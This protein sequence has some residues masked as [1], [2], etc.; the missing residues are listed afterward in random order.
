MKHLILL[1]LLISSSVYSKLTVETFNVGLAKG[2]VD[3]SVEREPEVLKAIKSSQ[4]DILCLQEA[5]DISLRKK[6]QK[7]LSDTYSDIYLTNVYQTTTSSRPSCGVKQL[8][9]KGKFVTCMQKQCADVEGDDF[10][11]C[12]LTKCDGALQ[13]LREEN[14]ECGS[15]LMAKVGKNQIVSIL[16]LI[17]PFYRAGLYAYRGSNGLVLLS[18][19]PLKNKKLIDFSD[20]STLNRR[21]A[22]QATVEY[23]GEDVQ[24]T[25]THL[26]AD[27]NVPYTGVS[28][29]WADENYNQIIRLLDE[30]LVEDQKSIVLGDFNCGHEDTEAGLDAELAQSC[31]LLDQYFA[32]PVRE[33]KECTYCEENSINQADNSKTN[34]LIDH[35]Y[36][37]GLKASSV[38]R[39]YDEK[40]EVEV[41]KGVKLETHISDHFGMQITI[42]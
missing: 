35:I 6:I 30:T 16:H 9:G 26:A 13:T 24:V 7:E 31:E 37:K 4:A 3:L 2:F 33:T 21:Q 29:N 22:L 41:Q 10:T 25:C 20:I 40:V 15:A 23:Q 5:W 34:S 42:D 27:L 8:F 32:D 36:L 19:L 14:R 38:K 28:R 11:D 12:I 18:K 17:N 39:V 1:T